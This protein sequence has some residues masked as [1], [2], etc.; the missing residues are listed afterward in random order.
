MVVDR[1]LVNPHEVA[2][3]VMLRLHCTPLDA[4][5]LIYARE[6]VF[7]N[8]RTQGGRGALA[9]LLRID[10]DANTAPYTGLIPVSLALSDFG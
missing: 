10:P 3:P 4:E 5:E 1:V 9:G 8:V 2:R 7:L 6:P